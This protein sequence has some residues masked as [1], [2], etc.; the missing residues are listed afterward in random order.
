MNSFKAAGFIGLLGI[1]ILISGY[2]H[3]HGFVFDFLVS[4][5]YANFG[6]GFVGIGITV[7]VIDYLN[8]RRDEAELKKQLIRDFGGSNNMFTQRAVRELRANGTKKGG[9]LSDGTLHGAILLGADLSGC[10]LEFASLCKADLT[11]ANLEH[12]FLADANLKN[13]VLK[14]ANLTE[15]N[16]EDANLK[17]ADL[18][19]A[20]LRGAVV[21]GTDFS[22]ANLTDT[23]CKDIKFDDKT[24]WP[25]NFSLDR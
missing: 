23:I 6:E 16:L 10:S 11:G 7:L 3:Q 12:A 20:S 8:M 24:I 21:F 22:E 1:V 18:S 19:G 9:W 13:T 17:G 2:I 25:S 5:F 4:D 14:F 15:A